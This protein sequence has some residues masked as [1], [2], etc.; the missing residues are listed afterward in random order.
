MVVDDIDTLHEKLDMFSEVGKDVR[1]F[2]LTVHTNK[3]TKLYYVHN[4]DGGWGEEIEE[5][6]V[7][8]GYYTCNTYLYVF[9]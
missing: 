7:A 3:K 4:K 2:L 1:R 9:Y 5:I 8:T 6:T